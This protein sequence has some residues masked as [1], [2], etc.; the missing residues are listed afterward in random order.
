MITIHAYDGL[1]KSEITKLR[2]T[3]NGKKYSLNHPKELL[4][5][6]RY[7]PNKEY[8]K[9]SQGWERSSKYYWTKILESNPQ[10]L[11]PKNQARITGD[12]FQTPKVDKTFIESFPQYKDFNRNS[13]YHHHIGGNGV[14]VAAPVDAHKGS[15]EIHQIEQDLGITKNA[16]NISEQCHKI[17][18]KDQRYY[19]QTSLEFQKK[20]HQEKNQ[21]KTAFNSRETNSSLGTRNKTLVDKEQF[22][23]KELKVAQNRLDK[24]NNKSR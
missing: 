19:G 8:N 10:C 7:T 3:S 20:I 16:Q 11:S 5:P 12:N 24:T 18:A 22:G 13:L 9:N 21:T 15:G 4:V 17:C 14:A 6:M 23:Q 2:T 1:L